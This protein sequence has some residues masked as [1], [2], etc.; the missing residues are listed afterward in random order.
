MLCTSGF[1]DDVTFGRIGPEAVRCSDYASGL[2]ILGP[3]L[4]SMNA[5]YKY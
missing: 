4:I 1:M 2:A 5:L 3:S